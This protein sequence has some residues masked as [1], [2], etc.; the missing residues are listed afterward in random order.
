M[1]VLMRARDVSSAILVVILFIH[2]LLVF[3]PIMAYLP[4]YVLRSLRAFY[5][6]Y[7]P[8]FP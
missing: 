2:T 8:D 3:S 7:M 5:G 4:A 6:E 1:K